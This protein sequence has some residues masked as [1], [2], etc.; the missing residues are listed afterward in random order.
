MTGFTAWVR[1]VTIEEWYPN[2]DSI[3]AD[4][5]TS[6]SPTYPVQKLHLVNIKL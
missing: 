6:K 3:K 5:L 1:N 2:V 4:A